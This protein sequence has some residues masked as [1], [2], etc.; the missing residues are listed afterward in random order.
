MSKLFAV[1]LCLCLPFAALAE[2][3]SSAPP[4]TKE[5]FLASLHFQQG[6]IVLPG[7]IA[8]LKL[9]PK[10]DLHRRCGSWRRLVQAVQAQAGRAALAAGRV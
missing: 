10:T 6:D 3:K 8:T 7:N 1:L 9:P 5:S 2:D 4:V